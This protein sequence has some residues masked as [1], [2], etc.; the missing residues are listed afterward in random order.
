MCR[1]AAPNSDIYKKDALVKY[2]T[3]IDNPSYKYFYDC[4]F[5]SS[6]KGEP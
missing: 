6:S 1:L 2:L 4:I 5:N 3:S